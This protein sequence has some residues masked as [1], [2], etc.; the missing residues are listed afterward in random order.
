MVESEDR[1]LGRGLLRTDGGGL[2][3]AGI[4]N[5]VGVPRNN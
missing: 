2:T 3:R 4:R 1:R 5:E